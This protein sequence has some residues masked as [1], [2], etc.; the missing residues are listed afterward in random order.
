[1]PPGTSGETRDDARRLP[2]EG[3]SMTTKHHQPEDDDRAQA[4]GFYEAYVDDVLETYVGPPPDHCVFLVMRQTSGQRLAVKLTGRALD[5]R[6]ANSDV[7]RRM[8]C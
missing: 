1:M 3:R 8:G 2:A 6:V 5:G 7:G 4:D